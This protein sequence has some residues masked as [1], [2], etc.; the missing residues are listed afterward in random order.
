LQRGGLDRYGYLLSPIILID[1]NC[2]R[3]ALNLFLFLQVKFS[4]RR[5]L[6]NKEYPCILSATMIDDL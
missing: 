6:R 5:F 1:I 2:T 4:L 3:L